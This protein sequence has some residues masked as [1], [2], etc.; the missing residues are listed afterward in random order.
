MLPIIE[1]KAVKALFNNFVVGKPN[2]KIRMAK[3]L[4]TAGP[5]HPTSSLG[6]PWDAMALCSSSVLLS[7]FRNYAEASGNL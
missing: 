2:L 3:N 4:T 7:N 1:L 6:A 5:N